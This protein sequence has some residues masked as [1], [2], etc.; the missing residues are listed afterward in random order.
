MKG[1][2]LFIDTV[3]SFL[4]EQLTVHG[5]ECIDG[6]EWDLEKIFSDLK[7]FTGIVIRSRFKIDANFLKRAGNL[8]FIARAGAGM[9]NIDVNA[10][11]IA[12]VR[13]IN[14][15]E[16]N[17]N[18]VA[19][20]CLGM[21]L[22]LLNNI[23]VADQQVRNG[24]WLREENRGTEVK[25]KTIG[26]IG[27]GNT[28]SSFAS[29]LSS[30]QMRIL[31]YDP[32]VQ[33]DSKLYPYVEQVKMDEIFS[34]ADIIS[35]HVPLTHET[36]SLVNKEY[37]DKFTRPITLINTSRGK[38]VVIKDLISALESGKVTGAALDVIEFEKTSFESVE[39]SEAGD[40]GKL[41]TFSNVIVTPHIAGWTK[42]SHFLISSV[43]AEK[44]IREFN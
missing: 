16:G 18:A 21:L 27:F 7:N 8:K 44:I 42:E 28:G 31:A 10:A 38:N 19:E 15:P 11:D 39:S 40:F 36:A 32:Y 9:E 1:K 29:K 37:L 22:C 13:C 3:H 35:L 2:I 26:L 5:W 41:C 24:N 30:M 33:I 14:A 25:N 34:S 17:R 4:E 20:H 6:S 23:L 43:L 12:S